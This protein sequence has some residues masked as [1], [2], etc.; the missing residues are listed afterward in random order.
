VRDKR[1]IREIGIERERLI[2]VPIALLA[3]NC[4]FIAMNID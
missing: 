2:K 1:K 3:G 4:P